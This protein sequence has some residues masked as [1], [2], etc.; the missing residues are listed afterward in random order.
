MSPTG[1]GRGG[2]H[3]RF[4]LPLI[5]RGLLDS[6]GESN[7][8]QPE[9]RQHQQRQCRQLPV[10]PDHDSDHA[11]QH[12]AAPTTRGKKAVTVTSRSWFT[13]FMIRRSRSP[14]RALLWNDRDKLSKMAIEI[15]AQLR[16][17]TVGNPSKTDGA[18]VIG[19]ARNPEIMMIA[20]A[21]KAMM[22][23]LS[24]DSNARK[25]DER[26]RCLAPST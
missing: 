8:P 3:G 19:D 4:P 16:Q 12:E 11:A 14:L 9:K 26:P 24:S 20:S 17:H 1:F 21:E 6:P 15:G 13:S 7:R 22:V 10:E 23:E 25:P 2:G 18:A 5:L